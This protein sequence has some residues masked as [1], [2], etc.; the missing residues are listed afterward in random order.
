MSVQPSISESGQIAEQTAPGVSGPSHTATPWSIAASGRLIIREVPGLAD[1]YDHYSVAVLS[2]H[3]LVGLEEAC[4]NAAFIVRAVNSH[5]A[6]VKALEDIAALSITHGHTLAAAEAI[7]V[8][9]LASV[10]EVQP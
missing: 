7:A 3:S 2:S 6:L 5:D 10:R 9:T 4:A 8:A 1:G